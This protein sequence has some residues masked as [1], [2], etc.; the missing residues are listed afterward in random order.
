MEWVLLAAIF[1]GVTLTA[2]IVFGSRGEKT[3]AGC[4]IVGSIGLIASLPVACYLTLRFLV[5]LL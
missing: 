1:Y 2:G 3:A 5:P 4:L